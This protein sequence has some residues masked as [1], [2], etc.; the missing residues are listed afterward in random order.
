MRSRERVIG[1]GAKRAAVHVLDRG[2]VERSALLPG[3]GGLAAEPGGDLNGLAIVVASNQGDR[4]SRARDHVQCGFDD[5][6]QRAF[7]AHEEVDEIH[8]RLREVAGRELRYDRHRVRRDAHVRDRPRW[9]L[10]LERAIR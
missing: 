5:H 10:D 6:A 7:G 2:D 9:L 1:H 3:I 8:S 4:A